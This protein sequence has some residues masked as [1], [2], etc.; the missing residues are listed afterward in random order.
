MQIFMLSPVAFRSFNVSSGNTYVADQYGIIPLVSSTADVLSLVAQGCSVLAPNPTDLLGKLIGANFNVNTDQAVPLYNSTPIRIRRITV[1][2][3]S[4]AGMSTAVG[5]FYTAVSKGGTAI[6]A[7]GQAY[8]GLTNATTA[9]D[10]TMAVPALVLPAGAL[11]YFSLTTPQGA[12]A[13]ANIAVYG[14]ALP[15]S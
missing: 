9:L 13:T 15:T 14:D 5:G 11:L 10:L 4:V 7:A 12:A 3:T 8:T 2:G 1:W 6:V